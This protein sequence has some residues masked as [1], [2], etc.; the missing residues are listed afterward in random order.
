MFMETER[1]PLHVIPGM[2]VRKLDE[3]ENKIETTA[4]ASP[5]ESQDPSA[6]QMDNNPVVSSSNVD[7]SSPDA[8][9]EDPSADP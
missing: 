9:P 1:P 8:S 5:E 3:N 2:S 4:D 6:D 7:A